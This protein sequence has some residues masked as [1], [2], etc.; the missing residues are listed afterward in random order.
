MSS[1]SVVKLALIT[2]GDKFIIRGDGVVGHAGDGT[3]KPDPGPSSWPKDYL[4]QL[5]TIFQKLYF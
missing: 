3:I 2:N 5:K 4:A 1:K